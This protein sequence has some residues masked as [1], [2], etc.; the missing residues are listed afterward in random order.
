MSALSQKAESRTKLV[1]RAMHQTYYDNQSSSHHASLA[2]DQGQSSG[3]FRRAS[4]CQMLTLRLNHT[5]QQRVRHISMWSKDIS[6]LGMHLREIRQGTQYVHWP[7]PSF[8]FSRSTFVSALRFTILSCARQGDQIDCTED[9]IDFDGPRCLIIWSHLH[10]LLQSI[11][12][13]YI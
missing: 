1:N 12:S 9:S 2:K 4:V 5:L 13:G 10:F 3:G 11:A 7:V 8:A 6:Y